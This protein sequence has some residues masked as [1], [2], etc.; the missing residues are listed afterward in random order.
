VNSSEIASLVFPEAVSSNIRSAASCVTGQSTRRLAQYVLELSAREL[1]NIAQRF[2]TDCWW[3]HTKPVISDPDAEPG[4]RLLAILSLLHDPCARPFL[5]SDAPILEQ[6]NPALLSMLWLAPPSH[7]LRAAEVVASLLPVLPGALN[8]FSLQPIGL[9]P[10]R[11]LLLTIA[12]ASRVRLRSR[13]VAPTFG[14]GLPSLACALAISR[15]L[16]ELICAASTWQFALSLLLN[17]ILASR[18]IASLSAAESGDD[19]FSLDVWLVVASLFVL[20]S[21][22]KRGELNLSCLQLQSLEIEIGP[23]SSESSRVSTIVRSCQ[24]H[25]PILTALLDL[26]CLQFAIEN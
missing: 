21:A 18:V 5:C 15:L 6:L 13:S 11:F 2:S 25:S 12:R 17:Q 9:G 19:A 16:S 4:C 24:E 8:H 20:A 22:S 1:F 7:Q 10:L 26:E 23:P 14:R 3:L